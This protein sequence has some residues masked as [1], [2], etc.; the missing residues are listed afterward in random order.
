MA[1]GG[2]ETGGKVA[3]GADDAPGGAA[4]GIG[5]VDLAPVGRVAGQVFVAVFGVKD[6]LA[7]DAVG[8]DTL[9]DARRIAGPALPLL[10]PLRLVRR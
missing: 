7:V 10:V 5:M 6:R 2:D 1:Q 3:A 4:D 9:L 8:S